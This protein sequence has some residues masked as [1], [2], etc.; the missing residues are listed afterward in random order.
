MLTDGVVAY[1]NT[2]VSVTGLVGD[3]IAPP[4]APEN[5]AQY[6]CIAYQQ[7]SYGA[8][9]TNDGP[10]GFSRARVVLDCFGIRKT[11]ANAVADA[12]RKV[13]QAFAGDLP[14]GTTVN[15]IDIVNIVD[16]FQVGNRVHSRAVHALIRFSE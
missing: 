2:Q 15:S 14:D 5:L 3:R 6:P 10:T 4:P 16:G 7:A 12:V 1:L 9:I 8:E 13:L 11:D